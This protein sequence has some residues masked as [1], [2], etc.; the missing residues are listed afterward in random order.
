MSD[1]TNKLLQSWTDEEINMNLQNRTTKL[2]QDCV[3]AVG[4]K[5]NN[6][7]VQSLNCLIPG[8][9]Q[10]TFDFECIAWNSAKHLYEDEQQMF[11]WDDISCIGSSA[12][13]MEVI[14]CSTNY[15][16][17]NQNSCLLLLFCFYKPILLGR[18]WPRARG[19]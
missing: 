9:H 16:I 13:N 5:L 10:L 8:A 6:M 15:S 18:L 11:N 12:H 2:S 19:S 3:Y 17:T 14:K 1:Y 4:H 7:L